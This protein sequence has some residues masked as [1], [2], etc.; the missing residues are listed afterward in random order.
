MIVLAVAHSAIATIISIICRTHIDPLEGKA[1]VAFAIK[2][3]RYF[4]LPMQL[5]FLALFDT[6]VA[7]VFWIFGAYGGIAAV[8]AAA[9]SG[10][11][12]CGVLFIWA[13]IFRWKN[14]E[15]SKKVRTKREK[16]RQEIWKTLFPFNIYHAIKHTCRKVCLKMKKH[17]PRVSPTSELNY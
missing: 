7:L 2:N 8:L 3:F 17:Q 5:I 15:L 14:E 6:I 1:A 13:S 12:T 11:G 10:G 9:A 16:L 4:G